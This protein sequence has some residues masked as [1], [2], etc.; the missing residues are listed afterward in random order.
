MNNDIALSSVPHPQSR[1]LK[2]L[3]HYVLF[4]CTGLAAAVEVHFETPDSGFFLK[5]SPRQSASDI[6]S[7]HQSG[8]R[9]KSNQESILSVDRF[10]VVQTTQPVSIR[11][12]YGPFSTKQT[13]PARYIVPDVV[14]A[15]PEHMQVNDSL[16]KNFLITIVIHE[17]FFL[18]PAIIPS[19][20]QFCGY[21]H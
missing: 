13:V 6:V 7:S 17:L 18:L 2:A 3:T 8:V 20:L 1:V 21:L 16:P 12:S 10:T 19:H 9:I 11:A 15:Q 4:V 5:H 14:E